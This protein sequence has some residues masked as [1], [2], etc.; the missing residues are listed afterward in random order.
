MAMAAAGPHV[1]FWPVSVTAVMMRRWNTKKI[2]QVRCATPRARIISA[3]RRTGR[4]TGS[5]FR[6]SSAGIGRL[7]VSREALFRMRVR[8]TSTPCSV[9]T[10]F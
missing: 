7:I 8:Q 1:P 6:V 9:L 10:G 3:S 5:G 4:N 2:S